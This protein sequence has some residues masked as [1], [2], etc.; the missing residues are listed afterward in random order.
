VAA[1]LSLAAGALFG[2]TLGTAAASLGST[3]GATLAMLAGRHLLR[4]PVRAWLGD[5][6]GPLDR[7][8]DR[9]GVYYLVS[10]RLAPVVPYTL[11]NLG[12]ALTRMRVVPYLLASLVGML[13]MTFL[14]V[15]AGTELGRVDRPGRVLSPRVLGA[16]ILL[17][18]L[19]LAAR[20]FLRSRRDR[21]VG[22]VRPPG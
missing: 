12:M 3:L 19:P 8:V 14:L 11:V 15:N 20:A 22:R 17:G 16:L 13:P 9:D 2:R 1:G 5:R 10:L 21:P 7:G 18:L 4:D 6:L